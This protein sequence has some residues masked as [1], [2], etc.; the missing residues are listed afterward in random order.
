[1]CS[2]VNLVGEPDALN[3]HVRFEEGEVETGHG[4]AR[5]APATERAGNRLASPKQPRHLPTLLRPPF[6][7]LSV[8]FSAPFSARQMGLLGEEEGGAD[9][10][11]RRR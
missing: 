7:A 10:R 11:R 4:E 6:S 2:A 5:E 8:P 1:V 9:R 3:A